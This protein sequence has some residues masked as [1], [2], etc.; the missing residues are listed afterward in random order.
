M[1]AY[2]RSLPLAIAIISD[3][4][5]VNFGGAEENKNSWSST[6]ESNRRLLVTF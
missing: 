1:I 3:R 2:Q 6:Q 5:F 4:M